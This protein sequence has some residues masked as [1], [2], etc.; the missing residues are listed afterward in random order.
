[1]QKFQFTKNRD[2]KSKSTE[3]LNKKMKRSSKFSG[4]IE[5]L[6]SIFKG[7]NLEVPQTPNRPIS[8]PNLSEMG[9]G[10]V[11]IFVI[12]GITPMEIRHMYQ[13]HKK[14]YKERNISLFLGSTH[15]ITPTDFLDE[16][17]AGLAK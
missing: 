4:S 5:N 16:L 9:G 12:G 13:L 11:M 10:V 15:L 1:M 6:L 8:M 7:P 14:Y 17:K 3:R 2:L